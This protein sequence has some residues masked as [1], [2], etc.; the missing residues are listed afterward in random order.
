[1]DNLPRLLKVLVR[2]EF[3]TEFEWRQLIP[4]EATPG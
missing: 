3:L 2:L 4:P 1:M